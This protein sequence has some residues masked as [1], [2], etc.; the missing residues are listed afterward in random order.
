MLARALT[1]DL[2]FAQALRYHAFDYAILIL[3]GYTND[4]SV[5]YKAEDELRQAG[6]ED[7]DLDAVHMALAGVYLMQGRKELVSAELDQA[8]ARNPLDNDALL[9]REIYYW[10]SEDNAQVKEVAQG[11]L[12]RE[13]LF[14]PARMFLSETLRT[15][16]DLPGAI[17]EQQRILE[18]APQNINAVGLLNSSY[19]DS[20]QFETAETLLEQKRPAFAGNFVWRSPGLCCWPSRASAKRLFRRWM[21][22]P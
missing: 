10:L 5:L 6:R 17:R 14:M 15:E 19:L 7:P 11:V 21:R 1:L 20:G 4:T 9:W 12:E 22:I 13:P 3:N 18:Q 8:L 2:H 16:G